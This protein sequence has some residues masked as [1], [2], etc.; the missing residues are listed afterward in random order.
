[1]FNL[2]ENMPYI[3]RDSEGKITSLSAAPASEE[4]EFLAADNAEVVAFQNTIIN[5]PKI[6]QLKAEM[7]LADTLIIRAMI[8]N[9]TDRINTHKSQQSIRRQQLAALV[10]D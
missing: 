8:E 7:N 6:L 1:L 2:G 10:G 4:Q 5:L 9:D 3:T